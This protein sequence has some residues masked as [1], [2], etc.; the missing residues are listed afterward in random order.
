MPLWLNRRRSAD[1]LS[2]AG[3]FGDFPM[4][5]ETYRE[6]LRDVFDLPGLGSLLQQIERREVSVT[7]REAG[8]DPWSAAYRRPAKPQGKPDMDRSCTWRR[9]VAAHLDPLFKPKALLVDPHPHMA[10]TASA[11]G[12]A[13]RALED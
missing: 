9:T 8:L 1:L 6:C 3:D 12:A 10:P 4:V 2:V 7:V 11:A 5:L 13:A